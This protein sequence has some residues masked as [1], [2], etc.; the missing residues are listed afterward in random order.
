MGSSVGDMVERLSLMI[1]AVDPDFRRFCRSRLIDQIYNS[2]CPSP[3]GGVSR[4]EAKRKCLQIGMRKR[5][6]E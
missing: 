3:Y 5:A 4:W 1:R 2:R 6:Y